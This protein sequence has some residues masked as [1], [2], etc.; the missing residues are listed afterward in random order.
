MKRYPLLCALLFVYVSCGDNNFRKVEQLDGFRVLS[1]EAS[2][3]EV[4]P[5]GV[6]TLRVFLTD[7]NG[8]TGG[9]VIVGSTV[10][11]IDPGIS[12]GASV[13]CD[14]D[15]AQVRTSYTIDTTQADLQDNLSTGPSGSLAVTVPS[16]VHLGRSNREK[17]NGVG[18]IVI[19]TFEVDGKEYK[20]FKRILVSNRTTLNTNPVGSSVLLN[21]SAFAGSPQKGDYLRLT[22]SSPEAYDYINVDGTTETRI[23]DLQV[24][25]FVSSAEFDR[26]KASLGE[27]V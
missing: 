6:S 7:P 3:P 17:L 27:S 16:T 11:C 25:W 14:H 22:T 20:S 26:P 18:Y 5:G 1:I 9:R 24:S 13:S 8:P 4:A 21:G 19:F 12:L 2:A 10:A 15:P 23:E